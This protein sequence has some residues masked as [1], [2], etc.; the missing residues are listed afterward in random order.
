MRIAGEHL[1]H[2]HLISADFEIQYFLCSKL[3][4]LNQSMS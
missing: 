1:D 2:F 4:F 3:A